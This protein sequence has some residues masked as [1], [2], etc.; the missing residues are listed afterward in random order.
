MKKDIYTNMTT[1]RSRENLMRM[2]M[3][4]SSIYMNRTERIIKET[5]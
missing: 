4:M 5:V 1:I 2:G 3:I